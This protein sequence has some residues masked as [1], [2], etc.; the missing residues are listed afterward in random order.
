MSSKKIEWIKKELKSALIESA[1][2]CTALLI[3]VVLAIVFG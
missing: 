1:F 2:I 3:I